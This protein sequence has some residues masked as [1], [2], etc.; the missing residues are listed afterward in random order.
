MIETKNYSGWI[1][2][3]EESKRW[4]ETFK[5]TRARFFYNPIKQNW[6]HAYALAEHLGLNIG[7]FKPIVV[8]SDNC[9]LNVESKTPVVYSCQLKDLLLNYTREIIPQKD[10]PLI[11]NRLSNI[12]LAGENIARTHIQ[13]IGERLSE[14]ETAMQNGRCPR[15][16]GELRLRNGK[17]GAFYGC[18][19]YPKCRFTYNTRSK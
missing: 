10:V 2:G 19:N 18:S 3:S 13:S 17:Y 1:F 9:D 15:C 7:V 8:F 6:G 5:T 12:S 16:G 11:F 4:K 14:K